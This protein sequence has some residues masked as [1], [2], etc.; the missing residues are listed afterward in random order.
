MQ[1]VLSD[2]MPYTTCTPA[3]SSFFAHLMFALSSNRAF[4][5]TMHTAC[6]PRSAASI[7][8]GTR[9]ESELVRYT[10][11]LIASTSGSATACFTKRS[12]E[13]VKESYG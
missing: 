6:L 11:C 10:V 9:G 4:S 8:P 3:C 12:T 2:G 13:V 1:C 5:S 7:S